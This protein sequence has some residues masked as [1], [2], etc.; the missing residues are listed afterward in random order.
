MDILFDANDENSLVGII[1]GVRVRNIIKQLA[2][3]NMKDGFFERDPSSDYKLLI[4]LGIPII[5]FHA[6]QCSTD[7][8]VLSSARYGRRAPR[9]AAILKAQ[10]VPEK[11]S[12]AAQGLSPRKVQQTS[13][14]VL[15]SAINGA[16]NE[17]SAT[18]G[19]GFNCLVMDFL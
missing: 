12:A 4:F 15:T 16:G 11:L 1:R 7:V 10:D 3:L 5:D 14:V 13:L 8:C 18:A 9:S 19:N 2:M 17:R 6:G